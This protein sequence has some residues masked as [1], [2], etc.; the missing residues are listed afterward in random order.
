VNGAAPPAQLRGRKDVVTVPPMNGS[1]KLIT[2]FEDFSDPETPF[3]Y[4]CHIL[5]HEDAGMMGHFIVQPAPS[6]TTQS[7]AVRHLRL[8][9][10]LLLSGSETV[11]ISADHGWEALRVEVYDALGRPVLTERNVNRIA[12]GRLARGLNTVR[13]FTAGGT[14]VFKVLKG[15]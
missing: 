11:E 1:V 3:M 5:S 15:E 12:G 14:A 13:I 10:T 9:P 2:R 6:G 7:A 8:W 4:H